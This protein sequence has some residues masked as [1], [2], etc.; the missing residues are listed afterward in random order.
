MI[1]PSL[2]QAEGFIEAEDY[3]HILNCLSRSAFYQIVNRRENYDLALHAGRKDVAIVRP[4]DVLNSR[5]LFANYHKRL[6][7]IE[8]FVK[9]CQ[10]LIAYLALRL[11]ID[12]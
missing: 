12:R 4:R 10:L 9:L 5:R 6:I 2:F 3:I 7:S 8:I 1:L 11:T